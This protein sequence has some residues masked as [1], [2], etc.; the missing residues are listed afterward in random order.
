MRAALLTLCSVLLCVLG[1]ELALRVLDGWSLRYPRLVTTQQRVL[2]LL[3][4]PAR[5]PSAWELAR[6]HLASSPL[7]PGVDPAW[8][9]EDPNEPESVSRI[10]SPDRLN[11]WQEY[12]SRGLYGPQSHY[13][14]NRKFVLDAHETDWGHY[15]ARLPGEL[16]TFTPIDGQSRPR[17]RFPPQERLPSGLLTNRQGWRGAELRFTGDPQRVLIAFVG[18]STTIEGHTH[19]FSHAELVG[20]WLNRWAESRALPLRFDVINAGREGVNSSDI[21]QITLQEVLPWAPDWVIYL[22]GANQTFAYREL[23]RSP[24][25]RPLPGLP[26][27]QPG[28]LGRAAAYSAILHRVQRAVRENRPLITPDRPPYVLD[29]SRLDLTPIDLRH[30]SGLPMQWDVICRDLETM[31]DAIS[32]TGGRLLISSYT[33][34]DPQGHNLDPGRHRFIHEQLLQNSWPLSPADWQELMQRQNQVFQR[35][36]AVTGAGFL[37]VDRHLPRDPDLFVDPI[38]VNESGA[39][40]RGWIVFNLLVPLVEDAWRRG[41]LPRHQPPLSA[42]SYGDIVR[43]VRP[44][45]APAALPAVASRPI[46]L[47]RL[48]IEAG[49]LLRPDES[50]VLVTAPK[51][52]SVAAAIELPAELQSGSP[53]G[54]SLSIDLQVRTGSIGVGLLRTDHPETYLRA[55]V[56]AADGRKEIQ[57][58]VP[59]G[60]RLSHLRIENALVDQSSEVQLFNLRVSSA[61]AR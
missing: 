18:A 35:L 53:S 58:H 10:V 45:G 22:E 31:H 52:W 44:S 41:E 16:D 26:S 1:M 19:R 59:P 5:N 2:T 13:V 14:W 49:A 39:R 37:D 30:Y 46:A 32:A 17:Y 25:S 43:V 55:I 34:F 51:Q 40:L 57:I 61:S 21:A 6:R 11:A 7:A 60:N 24:D 42:W 36:A 29:R 28:P 56:T 4:R 47:D 33:W 27:A 20:H 48:S 54:F 8:F 50:A 15:F 3:A 9:D 23:V 12:V 38:H